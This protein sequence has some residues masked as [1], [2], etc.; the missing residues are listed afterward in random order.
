MS[1]DAIK[2][3]FIKKYL[4]IGDTKFY[5]FL[6]VYALNKLISIEK[7]IYNGVSPDLEFLD[8]HDQFII[9]YRRDGGESLLSIAKCFRKAAHKIYRVRL[10][11]KMTDIN[12]RFLNL[13]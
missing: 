8:L 3:E 9:L 13:V 2:Q 1:A 12:L 6:I 5:Q 11:K 4:S 10:K 7:K